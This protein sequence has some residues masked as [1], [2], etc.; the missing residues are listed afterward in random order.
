MGGL[1]GYRFYYVKEWLLLGHSKDSRI[2]LD[3]NHPEGIDPHGVEQT[4]VSKT[5][6]V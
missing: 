1:T 5:Y 2:H 3:D 6:N 4:T